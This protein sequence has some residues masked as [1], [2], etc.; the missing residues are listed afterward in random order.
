M[1]VPGSFV[2]RL[3]RAT[4][5]LPQGKF[6]GTDSNTLVLE[7]YRMSAELQQSGN[8]TNFLSLDVNGM[9]QADMQALS[10]IFAPAQGSSVVP[11]AL[12]ARALVILE[13]SEGSGY[14]QVFEGQFQQAQA[15]YDGIPFVALHVEAAA[16]AG[17]Q[18]LRTPPQGFS[19]TTQVAGLCEQL[20][21][22]MGFGFENN[23][24][25]GTLEKPYLSGT[26][27]DQ[28][29]EVCTAA[30]VDYY[31]D[32]KSTLI[33][34]PKNQPRQNQP[35]QVL[36][37]SSGLRGYVTLEQYGISLDCL[38]SAARSLGSPF[39][40]QDSDVPGTNGMWYPFSANHKLE[41]IKP[42]GSWFSHL[43]CGPAPIS[44]ST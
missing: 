9:R 20:A 8:F 7:G 23:G 5:V 14:L 13:A 43:Q 30:G 2:N 29:R 34:C 35:T 19:G 36:S 17:Q 12:N 24:V 41:S 44:A 26:L 6:P 22:Q 37:P 33:I 15:K 25:T 39:E 18:Y 11:T 16:G 31:F 27:M 40:L 3:L 38:F 4:F 1:S 32:A 42:G 10:V 21:G 28:F